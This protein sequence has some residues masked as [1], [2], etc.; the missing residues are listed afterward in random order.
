MEWRR[1]FLR[2]KDWLNTAH[3]S[4]R[5]TRSILLFI[6]T[7]SIAD[8]LKKEVFF[9]IGIDTEQDVDKKYVHTRGYRNIREGMP[10]LLDIF[11][12]FNA[13]STWL[14]TPDVAQHCGNFFMKL[15]KKHEIGC[16]VH[17]EFFDGSI[18]GTKME[19][20]LP[21]FSHQNQLKMLQEASYIIRQNVG[22]HPR[23]FRAG[24]FAVNMDTIRALESCGFNV[25]CSMTPFLD[26]GFHSTLSSSKTF[27]YFIRVGSSDILE[28]PVT[29]VYP[30][31][32][33]PA[34]LRP[35]ASSG[36]DMINVMKIRAESREDPLVLNMMFHSMELIDPNPYFA[37]KKFFKNIRCVLEYAYEH[38]V[39]FVTMNDLYDRLKPSISSRHQMDAWENE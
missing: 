39:S 3:V 33:F 25:D 22:V 21:Q 27:P 38:N 29:I 20:I 5:L 16:H 13:K 26:W 35:S 15:A 24:R 2:I 12:D 4:A 28:I 7:I 11:D 19:K 10:R 34:W 14:I 1:S 36:S 6:R 18:K 23:S 9:V 17:P 30:F 31:G 37:S 32:L 8:V